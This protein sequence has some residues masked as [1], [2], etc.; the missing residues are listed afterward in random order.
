MAALEQEAMVLLD[1]MK[2]E[3]GRISEL[4]VLERHGFEKWSTQRRTIID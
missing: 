3:C 2:R 1:H 4:H